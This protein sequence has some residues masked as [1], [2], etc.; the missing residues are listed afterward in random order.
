MNIWWPEILSELFHFILAMEL[1]DRFGSHLKWK[2]CRYFAHL[3]R[4]DSQ[5]MCISTLTMGQEISEKIVGL[6]KDLWLQMDGIA[7]NGPDLW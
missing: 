3:N 5:E 2:L 7:V 4:K 6:D 1:T